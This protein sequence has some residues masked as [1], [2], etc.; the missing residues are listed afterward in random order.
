MRIFYVTT[1]FIDPCS[2]LPIDGGLASYLNKITSVLNNQGHDINVIVAD[3]T[4]K[5]V[6]YNGIH[7]FFINFR[8]KKT[9]FQRL[10]WPFYPK[11]IKNRLKKHNKYTSI[12]QKLQSENKKKPIDIIQ[13]ASFLATGLSPEKN[14]PSCVRISS[15]AKLWQKNYNYFDQTEIDNEVIQFKN[16]RFLYGPSEYIADYIKKD[17]SLT[18]DIKIIETPFVPYS[19]NEDGCLYET[20]KEKTEGKP[21]LLFFGTVGLLKGAKEIADIIYNILSKYSD[22]YFVLVGKC[23]KNNKFDPID[24]IKKNAKE[25]SGRVVWLPQTTH[26]K[27]FPIIR[28]A[29]AVVLPS[30]VDNLPN[31]C[32]EAMGLKKIVIGS[33]GA[34]FEQLIKEGSNG[35]LCNAGDAP[36]LEKAIHELMSLSPEECQNISE[37]AYQRSLSLALEKIVP[38]VLGYYN[39]VIKNWK[40]KK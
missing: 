31:A 37:A 29:K 9:F 7:V 19:G 39:F 16:A 26:D 14:I 5:Y 2:Q 38:Q 32:I 6:N 20:L 40:D 22:L 34:S 24:S 21:Y 28:H 35:L 23:M 3:K 30:R 33:R 4:D 8:F 13:Y 18:Q 12:S 27:L 17:L 1:E 25:F 11:K 10:F 36:S 15:Y